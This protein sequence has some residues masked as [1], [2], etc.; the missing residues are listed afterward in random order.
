MAKFKLSPPWDIYYKQID[1]FFQYDREVI[2]V[3]D[4]D[5]FAINLYVDSPAKAASLCEFLPEEK[6]FG[7]VTLAINIIPSNKEQTIAYSV[8]FYAAF[9]GNPI[10]ESIETIQGPFEHDLVYILFE[11]TVV[12]YF[13]DN[14]GDYNGFCST[15]YEN[16][17]RDIFNEKEGVFYCTSAE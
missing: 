5:A 3:F 2:V 10:V 8:P 4:E 13:T 11:K 9:Y 16:I 7:N 1:A 15:L 12:Q 14:L 17:A 6:D